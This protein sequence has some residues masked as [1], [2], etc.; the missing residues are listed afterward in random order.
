MATIKSKTKKS[1]IKTISTKIS[2]KTSAAPSF[3]STWKRVMVEP[4]QFYQQ[5]PAKMGYKEPSVFYLKVSALLLAILYVFLA[6]IAL[7]MVSFL[8]A[9]NIPML[10]M[11]SA[12]GAGVVA[13]IALIA[14]P[15]LLLFYWLCL[16][17]S[18]GITHLFVMLFGGTK[19][20][21]ETFKAAAYASA[22]I[23]F[24][25]I[26]MI[27]YAA[28]IYVIVLNVIGIQ[29]RQHL[30]LG[31]SIAVI[32]LPLLFF[33]VLFLILFFTFGLFRGMMRL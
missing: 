23:L 14:F 22:P 5:L 10:S 15:F 16:W 20:F 8:G 11:I 3:W 28:S 26:P 6:F 1:K 19:G 31:K 24:S 7:I 25:F 18:A 33:A 12:L 27:G 13:L 32:L 29:K 30:N 2:K 21:N 17:I 4:A 9:L